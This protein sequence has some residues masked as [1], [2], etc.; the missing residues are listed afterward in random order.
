MTINEPT[1]QENMNQ[2][3]VEKSKSFKTYVTLL[4][5]FGILGVLAGLINLFGAMVSGFLMVRVADT[6]FNLIFG[7]LIF[8]CSRVLARGKVLVIWLLS[9]CVLF[10]IIYSYIMGRGFNF[11]IAVLG[12]LSIWQLF[13]LFKQGELS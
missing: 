12:A 8:I 3:I 4:T 6:I 13:R 7:V 5:V 11:V 10:S 1:Q 2:R 9:G